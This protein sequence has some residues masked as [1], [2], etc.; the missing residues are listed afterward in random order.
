MHLELANQVSNFYTVFWLRKNYMSSYASNLDGMAKFS[1][2][3]LM[4]TVK[5]RRKFEKFCK[6]RQFN[7]VES[8]K[9]SGYDNTKFAY[10]QLFEFSR[11][12]STPQK[13]SLE[14]KTMELLKR[15]INQ[16]HQNLQ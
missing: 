3:I 15:G 2:T 12:R 6:S 8:N 4:A 13:F 14:M 11:M 9:N 1:N 7:A 10:K 16:G 5:Y